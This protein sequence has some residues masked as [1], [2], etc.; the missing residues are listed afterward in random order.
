MVFVDLGSP[1]TILPEQL[2]SELQVGSQK[3]LTLE[4]G[5]MT[6]SISAAP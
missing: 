3:R 6:V 4:V 1:S 2:L 5:N